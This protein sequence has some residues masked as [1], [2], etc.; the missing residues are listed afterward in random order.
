MTTHTDLTLIVAEDHDLVRETLVYSLVSGKVAGQVVGAANGQEAVDGALEANGQVLVLMDIE[1]PVMNGVD[2][3][4]LIKEKLPNTKVVM[5][6]SHASNELVLS[7]LSAGADAYCLKDIS[8]ERLKL[9]IDE[10]LKGGLWLDPG[11]AKVL[12][13]VSQPTAPKAQDNS[14]H[15]PIPPDDKPKR[16]PHN[17]N[18]TEREH[19]VLTLITEG[20]SNKEIAQQLSMSTHTVKTHVTNIIQKMAVSD[21]TQAAVKAIRNNMV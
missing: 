3:C 17:P 19:E 7:S 1:M 4:K 20:N 21:R 18:L 9:V 5:L 16:I 8:I 13:Q 12:H 10:T 15:Q 6:T 2:G 14:P 11:V